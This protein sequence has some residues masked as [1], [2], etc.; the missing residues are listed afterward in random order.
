MT[1]IALAAIALA[2]MGAFYFTGSGWFIVV[3]LISVL[4][5]AGTAAP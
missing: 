1:Q 5:I 3:A 4:G 2:G